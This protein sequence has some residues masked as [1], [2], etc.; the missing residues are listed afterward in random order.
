MGA[1]LPTPAGTS[2]GNVPPTP[3][4]D[5]PPIPAGPVPDASH[6]VLVHLAPD[7]FCKV[8]AMTNSEPL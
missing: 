4:G 8:D 3:I 1:V 2:A 7:S 5:G 6:V